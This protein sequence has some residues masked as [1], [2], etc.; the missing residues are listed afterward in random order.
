MGKKN[1]R[2]GPGVKRAARPKQTNRAALLWFA[3]IAVAILGIFWLPWLLSPTVPSQGDSYVLGFNNRVAILAFALAILLATAASFFSSR[4]RRAYQWLAATPRLFPPWSEAPVEYAILITFTVI[5]CG[6]LWFWSQYLVDIAWCEA[7]MFV[8]DINLIALGQ[9]PYRDFMFIYGPGTLY[10]PYWL[11]HLSGTALS[12]E[13]SYGIVSLLFDAAGFLA[14]F[15]FLRSLE[16]EKPVRWLILLICLAMWTNTS[17][18][19]QYTVIRFFGVAASLILLD[20]VARRQS[21]DGAPSLIALIPLGLAATAATAIC[22]SISPDIGLAGAAGVAAYGLVLWLRRSAP[23]ALVCWAGALFTFAAT[24]ALFPGY[25]QSIFDI[26][27]GTNTFPVFPSFHNILMVAIV[28]TII[29][30]LITSALGNLEEARAPLTLALAIG[31]GMMLPAAFSRCDPGHII[32]NSTIPTLMMFPAALAMGKRA[33]RAWMV[34]YVLGFLVFSQV[35]YWMPSGYLNN[36]KVGI[37]EHEFY[38]QHPDVVALWK[39]KWDALLASSPN[40]KKLHWSNVL[41]F[42][43]ALDRFT[44]Q[45]TM[46]L[47][48]GSEWNFAV[49]RYLLLQRQPPFDYFGAYTLGAV[50]PPEVQTKVQQDSAY[51]FLL[52]PNWA[53]APLGGHIDMEVYRKNE[54][55]ALSATIAFPVNSV[56]KHVPYFP[57]TEFVRQMLDNYKPVSRFQNFFDQN[58][59]VF[60]KTG[61]ISPPQASTP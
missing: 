40:G 2:G 24:L 58:F 16:I 60:G 56:P 57:D 14:V 6:L 49:A 27:S 19:L 44:S 15:L 30:A 22:L 52:V 20:F 48:A 26:S 33:F 4:P 9:V 31:G 37:Q 8:Y 51:P 46:V 25:L 18:G 12:I 54:N 39:A 29:P 59:Y 34:V 42:P 45:G 55:A 7:R 61:S 10:V 53:L 17:M 41:P 23:R 28:L 13:Q 3:A 35:T 32:I 36:F 50:T 5:K 38:A 43:D 21:G 47:T 1:R 11:Y